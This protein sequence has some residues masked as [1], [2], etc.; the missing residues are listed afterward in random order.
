M[1]LLDVF[2]VLFLVI[3]IV[4]GFRRGFFVELASLVSIL[5]GIF[6]AIKFS[7]LTQS[8]LQ[9]H[10]SWNPKTIQ[11][12]SFALTFIL[13]IIGVSMLAKVFTAIAN[14]AFLGLANSILGGVLAL[15][16]AVLVLSILLNLFQKVDGK[17]TIV[18][19][20]TREKSTLYLPVQEVSRQI[21]P[22]ISEWFENFKSEG[23]EFEN[24]K[25]S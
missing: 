10:G 20:E 11:V 19:K 21:Y 5:L 22:T 1:N 24:P 15:F 16:R 17:F 2:I 4:Q 8:W 7:Y 9:Q 13:V 25:E 12:V 23:F 6:I 18:S 3:G 14:F